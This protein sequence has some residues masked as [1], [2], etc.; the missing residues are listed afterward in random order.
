M[1]PSPSSRGVASTKPPIFACIRCAE[2][3][4]KCDKQPQCGVCTKHNVQCVYRPPKVSRRKRRPISDD[5]TDTRL[6]HYEALLLEKGINPNEAAGASEAEQQSKIGSAESPKTIHDA[7]DITEED[8]ASDAN[9][10]LASDDDFTYILAGKS[11][12]TTSAH[13][14]AHQIH[15]L[16]QTFV[17]NIHPVTKLVHVPSLQPALEKAVANIERIP[18]GFEALMFAIYSMATLSLTDIECKES[19]GETR[20]IL[21]PRFVAATKAAL[22]RAK[23]MS[24]TSIVVLQALVFHIISIRDVCEPRAVWSLTGLA[25]RVAEAM[26]MRL[27][28]TLLG[29]S[30]FEAELHRRLWWQLKMHDFRAAELA[31]QAKFRDFVIDDTTP[32]KPANVNDSDL[33]PAMPNAPLESDKP[34]EMI[35][36][37]LRAE[38]ASFAAAQKVTMQKQGKTVHTS[39]GFTAMDDLK[40]KDGFITHLEDMI[41]TKFLRYCDPSQPVQFLTL[42]GAR[43]SGNLI[44]FT[45][46][47][48]R[49]W[50]N[51]DQVP[52]SEQELVWGVVI[53][54]LEQY[55]MMQSSPQLQRFAWNVPYFIQW[56]AV[57]H[58][59][60]TLRA[61]PLHV[62]AG[63]AWRLVDSLYKNNSEMML[64]TKRP[65]LVAVGNLCLKA[66]NSRKAA[67]AREGRSVA[68]PPEYITKLQEQREAAKARREAATATS[69]SQKTLGSGYPMMTPDAST[70]T[71]DTDSSSVKVQPEAQ[72]YQGPA[73]TQPADHIHRSALA[74]AGDDAFWLSEAQDTGF[75]VG[76]ADMMNIDTEAILGQDYWVDAPNDEVIDWAQWDVWLGSIDPMRPN[77]GP[78]P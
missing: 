23:F 62:E 56:H 31:G 27:D 6:K 33:H 70:T 78:G 11:S 17:E 36:I 12:I 9:D 48:P 45:A 54:L 43:A 1:K 74:G 59:L 4:I 71:P 16:W 40:I 58:V 15:Q 20:A 42:L 68:C 73:P 3:K 5:V 28:G 51:L 63:K 55:D 47:H 49:R 22:V 76:G 50:A 46:H 34:T 10:G 7:E 52:A 26:G 24:S 75:N 66:F 38:L 44:R 8:S 41:E 19:L 67:L 35:W 32:K 60:D 39:E 14:P 21:L 37:M 18:R 53:Q 29:L 30:P 13:P 77:S 2:R 72:V 69:F 61:N 65:I 25:I 64:S 57:I